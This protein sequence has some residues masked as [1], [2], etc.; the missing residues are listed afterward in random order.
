M[1]VVV[2]LCLI[3]T[4]STSSFGAL[5]SVS[6]FLGFLTHGLPNSLKLES[7]ARSNLPPLHC[8]ARE[9]WFK[10][11]DQ[12]LTWEG[13]SLYRAQKIMSNKLHGLHRGWWTLPNWIS[14]TVLSPNR[15]C[16]IGISPNSLGCKTGICPNGILPNILSNE[17]GICPNRNLSWRNQPWQSELQ[18]RN[19]P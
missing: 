14:P 8:L 5:C 6:H 15:T 2:I 9:F 4:L 10:D 19:L 13:Q 11:Y 17:T 3:S 7:G 18:N 1:M 16:L 12:P